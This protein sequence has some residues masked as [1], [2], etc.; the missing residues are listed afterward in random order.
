MDWFIISGYGSTLF[1]GGQ[2][3]TICDGSEFSEPAGNGC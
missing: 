3:S 2:V 1:K